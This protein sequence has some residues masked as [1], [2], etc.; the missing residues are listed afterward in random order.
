M[1]ALNALSD[2]I[3]ELKTISGLGKGDRVTTM[4]KYI[5]KERPSFWQPVTRFFNRDSRSKTITRIQLPIA[6]VCDYSQLIQQSIY[7]NNVQGQQTQKYREHFKMLLDI[8]EAL[9]GAR[10]GITN[11]CATYADDANFQAEMSPTFELIDKEVANIN[12]YM[13]EPID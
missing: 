1:T 3:F 10:V 9:L 5:D 7:L 11:L 13:T 2:L 4:Q 6:A 12:K 8:K